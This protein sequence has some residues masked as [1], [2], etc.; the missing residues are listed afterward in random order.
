MRVIDVQHAPDGL[1]SLRDWTRWAASRFRAAGIFFGHGTDNAL[2]EALALVLH[3]VHLDHSLTDSWLDCRVTADE[4]AAIGELVERR[5]AGRIPAA[6][7]IGEANFAGLSFEVTPDVLIPRSPIA[8]LV[9]TGFS[10]WLDSVNVERVLDLCT[11]SGCIGIATAFAFPDATVD[12]TDLSPAALAVAE[13]NIARH[14]VE[15]RVEA[16]RSDVFDALGARRYDLIVSNPPY[17]RSEDMLE[18]PAEYRHEPVLALEA[19]DDGMDIVSR[20]LAEAADH[21][22]PGGI[23][24]IEVGASAESLLARYPAVPFLWLDCDRGGDGVFLLTVEQLE[25]LSP[26]FEESTS[27]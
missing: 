8:E 3:A 13:R 22:N 19:G 21:L 24:V 7:L 6:Y 14:G 26:E 1:L 5:V 15:D 4:A 16:I 17:V 12:I 11:G 2:D 10:P 27:Q 25:E 18:L 23:I 20:I 9:E